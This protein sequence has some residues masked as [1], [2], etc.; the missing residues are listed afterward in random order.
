[1]KWLTY[2]CKTKINAI[3]GKGKLYEKEILQTKVVKDNDKGR[4]LA[5][6]EAVGEIT[7]KDDGKVVLPSDKERLEALESAVRGLLG[8]DDDGSFLTR[9][10]QMGKVARDQVPTKF[11]EL[12]TNLLSKWGV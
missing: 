1:M 9:Q 4:A 10:I 8:F 7:E 11:K 3:D 6:Q 5:A 12:V 2:K